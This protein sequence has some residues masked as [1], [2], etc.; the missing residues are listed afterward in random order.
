MRKVKRAAAAAASLLFCICTMLT[1]VSA[2]GKWE[3][4]N[5][6]DVSECMQ[7]DALL[8]TVSLKGSS[9]A[10]AQ[11]IT[12]INGILEYDTSLFTVEKEDILPAEKDLVKD[13][14]F[15]LAEG[16]FAVQYT[17]KISVKNAGT[18]LQIRLHTAEDASVGK[19]T[20][21]V[22]SLEWS[23][24]D[25]TDKQEVEHRVPAKITIKETEKYADGDVNGDGNVNLTD[26]RLAMQHYN[27]AALLDEA[28]QKRADVNKDGS[29]NLT[30][31]KLV[32]Q[33]YNGEMD[34]LQD[35]IEFE[36]DQEQAS[37]TEQEPDQEQTADNTQ[38]QEPAKETGSDFVIKNKVLKEY[39]GS[40]KNVII[41]KGVTKIGSRALADEKIKSITIPSSVTVI[42]EGAFMFTSIKKIT[43]PKTVKK[44]GVGAFYGCSN[45][46]ELTIL[47]KNLKVIKSKYGEGIFDGASS[48]YIRDKI[49]IKGYKSS[50]AEK[51]V[52]ELNKRSV[53]ADPCRRFKKAVFQEIKK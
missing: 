53:Y 40:A 30:D 18:L 49:T 52:E 1:S 34:E 31:V 9:T 13:Y 22:T 15:D 3:I 12:S 26:A 36:A 48:G 17:S 35:I 50:T 33:Y 2:A 32:M 10:K 44:I 42:D 20:V 38:E 37:D 7:G 51:M 23:G 46:K 25:S 19:T 47:N 8:L 43:I 21:C 6:L 4:E 27:G 14:S 45:L 5:T 28:Q 41:P 39:K 29:V 11:E 16:K 24:A